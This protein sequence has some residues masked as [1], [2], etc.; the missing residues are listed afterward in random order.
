M[1]KLLLGLSALPT[2]HDAADALAVAICHAHSARPFD[3]QP[4]GRPSRGARSWRDVPLSRL[5]RRQA[6]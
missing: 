6:P 1:V 3:P 2:P 5:T 4:A